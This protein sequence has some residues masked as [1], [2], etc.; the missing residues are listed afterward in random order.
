M[1]SEVEELLSTARRLTKARGMKTQLAKAVDAPL[2][3]VSDWLA[4]NYLP[5]GERALKLRDWVRQ[6][7]AQQQ[8]QSPGSVTP[9]PG[10]KTQSKAS[11][12]KKPQSGWKKR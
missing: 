9:P 8:Q 7:E 10:P 11:N 12:E 3:R 2:P 1:K 4:G 6:Q 5:S